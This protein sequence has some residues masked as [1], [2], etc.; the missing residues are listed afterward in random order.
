MADTTNT[1]K[2]NGESK[3]I[4][5]EEISEIERENEIP[6]FAGMTEQEEVTPAGEAVKNI[7]TE[8]LSPSPV[9]QPANQQTSQ[10]ANPVDDSASTDGVALTADDIIYKTFEDLLKL[11]NKGV[12]TTTDFARKIYE[13]FLQARK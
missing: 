8:K 3:P 1:N 10:P 9:S 7:E 2:L 12:A 4:L 5:P 6:A 13:V 11:I